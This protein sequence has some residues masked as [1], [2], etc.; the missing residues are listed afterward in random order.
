MQII[1]YQAI[2]REVDGAVQNDEEPKI[3]GVMII[4]HLADLII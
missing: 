2:Y 3:N 4:F 1:V